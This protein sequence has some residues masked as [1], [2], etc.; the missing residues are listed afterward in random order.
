M[1]GVEVGRAEAAVVARSQL[2]EQARALL[3]RGILM[4][5]SGNLSVKLPGGAICITPARL[6]YDVMEPEDIVIVSPDGMVLEGR[7]EPSSETGL[8]LLAY[9]ERPDL[10]ALVHT[11][12][13]HA[14]TIAVLGMTI[15]AVHYMIATL[16]VSEIGIAAYGTFGSPQL[17]RNVAAAFQAPALAVL[18]ANHGV[19]AGGDSLVRA[20]DAAE[21]VELLA[22][23]YY[24][25][26]GIGT[27]KILSHAQ[28][29]EV[30]EKQQAAR[31][32]DAARVLGKTSALVAAEECSTDLTDNGDSDVG[33]GQGR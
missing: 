5:T 7:R 13:G 9:K 31:L 23:L 12:S 14:T 27:P 32:R 11:H 4:Q 8:H 21:T 30:M 33:R 17:A 18:L 19:V 22:G 20:A 1:S 2:V 29:A 26:L 10:A 25:A 16:R 15:P 6:R 3:D 24:R 28:L